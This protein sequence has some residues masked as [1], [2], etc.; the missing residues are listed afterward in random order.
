MKESCAPSYW[1]S[2][3]PALLWVSWSPLFFLAIDIHIYLSV[4]S[5]KCWDLF[6]LEI[7]RR[8]WSILYLSSNWLFSVFLMPIFKAKVWVFLKNFFSF[9]HFQRDPTCFTPNHDMRVFTFVGELS[10]NAR[11]IGVDEIRPIGVIAPQMSSAL[12]TE[13]SFI[14]AQ[15]F[16]LFCPINFDKLLPCLYFQSFRISSKIDIEATSQLP[17]DT[18]IAF[19]YR[20]GLLT[21][22]S[23]LNF[24]TVARSFKIH[25]W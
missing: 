12:W 17:T 20:C 24:F 1:F 4:L 19:K 14:G 5:F 25:P 11:S 22:Y 6:C 18:A 9:F 2:R 15:T 21:E 7:L 3:S 10:I 13:I 16:S 8:Q 23:K